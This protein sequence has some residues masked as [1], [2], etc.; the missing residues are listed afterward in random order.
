[1]IHSVMS[2]LVQVTEKCKSPDKNRR[3]RTLRLYG[4]FARLWYNI[5]YSE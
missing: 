4:F 3:G 1:L 2:I 5:D